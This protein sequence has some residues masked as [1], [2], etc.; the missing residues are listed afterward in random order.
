MR[1][2]QI[3]LEFER[4]FVALTDT[5]PLVSVMNYLVKK[6]GVE[7]KWIIDS[8]GTRYGPESNFSFKRSA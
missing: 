1:S 7:D 3:A 4:S 5:N 2:L 6:R 8:A